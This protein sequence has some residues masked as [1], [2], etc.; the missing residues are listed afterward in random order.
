MAIACEILQPEDIY[1]LMLKFEDNAE[2]I[3]EFFMQENEFDKMVEVAKLFV[4][5]LGQFFKEYLNAGNGFGSFRYHIVVS[6]L[7]KLLQK[8]YLKMRQPSPIHSPLNL[9]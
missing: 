9:T 6:L 8:Y 3:C 5:K 7:K 4:G 2:A 1:N